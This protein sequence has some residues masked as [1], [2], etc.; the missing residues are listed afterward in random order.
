MPRRRSGRSAG[1]VNIRIAPDLTGR[2]RF[3]LA[4]LP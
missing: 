4:T 1:L 3:V 2:T